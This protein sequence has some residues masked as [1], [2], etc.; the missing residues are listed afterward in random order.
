MSAHN[1]DSSWFVQNSADTNTTA[2]WYQ[3]FDEMY[4]AAYDTNLLP[5]KAVINTSANN[6]YADTIPIGIMNFAYYTLKPD[7]MSTDIYFNFDT[8]NNVLSDKNPRPSFPYN[9]NGIFMSAPLVAEAVFANPVFL[10]SPQ[11]FYYDAYNAS[12]FSKTS[13]IQIDFGDGTGW[14]NY[15]PT[16]VSYYQPNYSTTSTLLPLLRVRQYN[17]PTASI[18][19]SSISRIPVGGSVALPPNDVILIEGLNVGV[20]NGCNTNAATGKTIIYLEGIDVMDAIPRN[21]TTVQM[22]YASAIRNN[23]IAELRNQGYKF[24]VV[25]WQNSRIDMRFNALYILNLLQTLKQQSTDDEQFIVM[26]ESMG[27]VIA[28]Y[29]LTY[30]E[31]PNYIR[32]DVLPFFTEQNDPQSVIYLATHQNIYNLPTNWVE[33]DKMHN[34]RLFISIDAPHRGASIPLSIQKAYQHALPIIQ[35]YLPVNIGFI[36]NAFNLFLN[37]KAAKQLL[38]EH[39]ST[40]TGVGFYK[41]YSS[42]NV[43]NSFMQQLNQMGNYPQFAKIMLMSNGALSGANQVNYYTNNQPRVPND[44]LMYFDFDYHIRILGFK[45]PL[46]G[47][48][49]DVRTNPDGDGRVLLATAGTWSI[50]IKLKWFGIRINAGYNT[51]LYKEDYA[52]TRPYSTSAGGFTGTR[53][54]LVGQSGGVNTSINLSNNYWLFNLFSISNVND[55]NGCIKF[56]AHTGLNGYFSLN[57]KF[58]LC[59]DGPYLGFVPVESALDYGE[60]G[61]L[62]LGRNLEAVNINTKLAN[63]PPQVDIMVGVPDQGL[64]GAANRYHPGY[65]NDDI[66]NL[67]NTASPGSA[68]NLYFSCIAFSNVD[69]VRRGFLNMEI[70]DEEL[71]LENN[72]LPYTAEYQAEYDLHVNQRNRHYQY[73]STV[74]T[75][76]NLLRGIYSKQD[77]FSISPTG[78]AT[79]IFDAANSPS[80]TPG[81]NG[82]TI[83]TFVLND[84]PLINCCTQSY[85]SMGRGVRQALTTTRTALKTDSYLQVYPNP[86]TGNQFTVKYQ[87]SSFKNAIFT[88]QNMAGKIIYTQPIYIPPGKSNIFSSFNLSALNLAAGLYLATINSSTEKITTKMLVVK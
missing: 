56:G 72:V 33:P 34:T 6:F 26:G 13:I 10:I 53:T 16:V 2:I 24:V 15:D 73:P 35:N 30:M 81:F 52:N 83:G 74:G 20:Y 43:R 8:V 28:R 29:V 37:A 12:H 14:H 22:I 58:S 40:E 44:K 23:K 49:L 11:Y 65:R 38:I 57:F 80:A 19:G 39:L 50:R 61:T 46:Y 87:L 59:T 17:P 4:Y 41:T 21:N 68:T 48:K 47:G 64:G 78:F 60:A 18:A 27:G 62:S 25:D 7:A 51:L 9:D 79:F 3:V 54:G 66:F 1:A 86:N 85:T 42:N 31:T 75:P 63:L 45:I 71:F 32:Q 82:T 67:T 69:T 76:A 77:P 70:G 84:V 5:K 88:L 36:T 55:G